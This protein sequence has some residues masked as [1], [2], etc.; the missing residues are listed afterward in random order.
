MGLEEA[1]HR[2][3]SNAAGVYGTNVNFAIENRA[4]TDEDDLA[5]IFRRRKSFLYG[6]GV[7]GRQAEQ[8]FERALATVDVTF[9][10]VDSLEMGLTD[11]DHYTEYL[12]GMTKA[13]EHIRGGQPAAYVGDFLMPAGKVRSVAEM[14]ALETRTKTLNPRWF[15]G[16]LAHGYEGAREIES[17]VTNTF[18]WS[19]TCRAVPGWVYDGIAE[20]YAL[21]ASMLGR[22]CEANPHAAAGLVGRLLEA[23]T[24]GYWE[25][26]EA[27]AES[28]KASYLELE[29][30]AEG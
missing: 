17:H 28:L 7:E 16:M 6:R 24:R 9:Q 4:W 27:V 19:A 14:V 29:A 22:L 25:P 12:G 3:F 20:T 23:S 26:S 11:V 21:D 30:A 2:V 15:E 8:L 13:V 1:A 18:G 10:N 5:R